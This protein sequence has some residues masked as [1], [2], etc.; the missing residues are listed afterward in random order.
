MSYQTKREEFFATM[1]QEGFSPEATRRILSAANTIQRLAV[2]GCNQELNQAETRRDKAAEERI[3]AITKNRPE[4][5][6]VDYNGD[7]RGAC[8]KIVFT[9][10]RYNSFGGEGYCVPARNY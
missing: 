10:G 3:N 8:V 5:V 6:E 4:V 2:L 7:P 1:A 9:S